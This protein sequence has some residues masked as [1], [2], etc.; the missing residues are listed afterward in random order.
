MAESKA[1]LISGAFTSTGDVRA[2]NL[3]NVPPGGIDS[4]DVVTLIDS[5]YVRTRADSA[6][7]ENIIDSA[8]VSAR[9]GGGGGAFTIDADDNIISSISTATPTAGSGLRNFVVGYQAGNA[10]TTGDDNIFIGQKSG[11]N[12][13]TA[14]QHIAIGVRAGEGATFGTGISIGPSAGQDNT[15]HASSISL[16]VLAGAYGNGG[17]S[18]HIGQQSGQYNAGIYCI[19]MGNNAGSSNSTTGNGGD[20]NIAIGYH[21]GR[22]KNDGHNNVAIGKEAG[23]KTSSAS[24]TGSNNTG[25]GHNSLGSAAGSH[26]ENTFVGAYTG[27]ALT[28]GYQ[29]TGIGM[30]TGVTLSSGY[31]NTLLGYDAGKKTN[32]ITTG[33]TNIAIGFDNG[34][35]SNAAVQQNVIGTGLIGKGNF[36][37]F[38][39]GPA[40]QSNN[41]SSW[42]TTSDERIKT[43]ITDFTLGLDTLGQVNVKTYNYLSDSDIATAHPE[44]ADSNGLVHEGLD[45]EKTIVGIMA[46]E[47]EAVLPNSVETRD[48]GIK[49]INKD[50]L[51]WVML[52]SI[53]EL[54]TAND[55]LVARV[56]ALENA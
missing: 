41:S 13:T 54:K 24:N 42:A 8:Y 29:N 12:V 30:Y 27:N 6:Y 19:Y 2:E 28:S 46:Q 36:T 18:I 1:R 26:Y 52:N 3:D 47:L 10:L 53:K 33:N 34:F 44:L 38:I 55:S 39:A 37:T 20:Y 25:I 9:S 50:E 56:E 14:G 49:S 23:G 15:N 5:N 31:R 48:N 32:P 43:N 45:T 4:A 35:N 21:A 22:A 17:S 11:Y 40:Y 16:G 7:I 51:F